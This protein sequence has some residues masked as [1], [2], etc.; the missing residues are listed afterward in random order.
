MSFIMS[1]LFPVG[2]AVGAYAGGVNACKQQA[3]IDAQ[4]ADLKAKLAAYIAASTSAYDDLTKM[5]DEIKDETAAILVGIGDSAADLQ[6]QKKNF[7]TSFV[8][9]EYTIIFIIIAV[10]A[11][12]ML[13]RYNLLTLNPV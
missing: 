1:V 5:T 2:I 7:D 6:T 8:A 10:G 11:L 4:T 13:K 12:L 3:A 9:L